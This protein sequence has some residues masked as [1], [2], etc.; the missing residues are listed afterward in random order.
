MKPFDSTKPIQLANGCRAEIIDRD[1]KLYEQEPPFLVVKVVTKAGLNRVRLYDPVTGMAPTGMAAV[2]PGD[3]LINVPQKKR[4]WIGIFCNGKQN[5]LPT[6]AVWNSINEVK[7]H[8]APPGSY[9]DYELEKWSIVEI[10]W[11]E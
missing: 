9:L 1:F 7:Q 10:E 4:G 8:I 5:G 3:C 6:T 11:E 2:P